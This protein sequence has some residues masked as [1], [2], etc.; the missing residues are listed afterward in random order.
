MLG[1]DLLHAVR[2]L[3]SSPV[4]LITAVIT[5]AL[6]IGA[7]TAIFSVANAV[8]LR[9]LPYRDPDRL[10]EVGGDL[11]VR[12]IFDERESY[13]NMADLRNGTAG[14][15]EDM[16]FV[17]TT[18]NVL[19]QADGSPEQVKRAFVT[20]N[21][22]RVLG[23]HIIAG[24]DFED[25]D[26]I[27]L[28]PPDQA[29][30]N[31]PLPPLISVI[32][33]EYWQRRFGGNTAILGHALQDGAPGTPVI[34]GVLAPGFQLEFRDSANVERDCDI[35]TALRANYDNRNRNSYFLRAIG[36]LKPGVPVEQ[37]R[38]AAELVAAEIRRN[39]SVYGGGDFHYHIEPMQQ[40]LVAEVRPA[41]L[42]L[43]GAV[44]FLLLIACANVA[45]LLLVR[46]SLRERELAVRSALGGSRARLIRQTLAEAV[47]IS[48]A[49][50]LVGVALAYAGIHE[51]AAISPPNLPRLDKISLDPAVLLFSIAAGCAAA[52]LFG[53]V[54]ALRASRPNLMQVLRGAGRTSGL[55]G[56]GLRNFVAIT[57]VSLSF[58]LLTGSGLMMRS[59]IALRH[60]DLG[61][62]SRNVLTFQLL[63]GNLGPK[64]EV[65]AAR[66]R[67]V[68]AALRE[69]GSV[70]QVT[71]SSL[72]PLAGGYSTIRWG[73]EDALTDPS[74]YQATDAVIVQPGFFEAMRTPVLAGRTFTD[75][76]SAPDRNLVVID[77]ML[78]AKA[79]PHESAVGKRILIRIRTPQPEWVEVIGVVAHQR[80]TSIAEPGHEQVYF[81]D[82]FLNFGTTGRWILRTHGDPAATA[83]AVRDAIHKLD[84]KLLIRELRPMD[85]WVN[86][87]QAGTRFELLLIGVFAAIAA[88]LASVGLYGVLATFVRQRTAEIGVR[89]AMGAAPSNILTLVLGEGIRLSAIGIGAGLFAAGLL[90][91][92]MRS[93]LVG[94]RPTDPFT[95]GTMVVF[96]FL[97]AAVS[98]AVPAVRAAALDPTVALRQE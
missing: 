24:R 39:F 83:P 33:Y 71:A 65:R 68:E 4:F 51:L 61:F 11:R 77:Q 63:P 79:F 66:I 50:T 62:D 80:A 98:C 23:A 96:F 86:Q 32:T 56:G 30:G 13:E 88:V 27:A 54:P 15:F 28:P 67:S 81:A 92:A 90:T 75:A 72:L 41:I 26:G 46:M 53:L 31:A 85:E 59:F 57:E 45:N 7:S 21:F 87:A 94:V 40:H 12:G 1:K 91:G 84:P 19:P 93:M 49:G 73:K 42:A 29:D 16:A 10:V 5:I 25:S 43:M 18:R 14:S 35:Y 74:K 95:F 69:I 82:G 48:G 47:L 89:M 60:V 34:V 97:I 55:G 2:T 22:F 9:P 52:M 36:R 37:A 44:L 70:E 58:V 38:R 8:L 76:D 64:P 17:G 20:T 6:G 78:A 3:R